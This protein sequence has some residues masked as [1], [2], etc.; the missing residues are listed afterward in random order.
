MK[1]YFK[2]YQNKIKRLI[3]FNEKTFIF[4]PVKSSKL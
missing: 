4:A 1:I 3:D 2:N